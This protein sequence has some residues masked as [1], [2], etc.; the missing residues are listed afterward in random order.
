[1]RKSV[2]KLF[3]VGAA[4][5]LVTLA[6]GGTAQKVITVCPSGCDFTSI[7]AAI[8]AAPDGST[9]QVK[10]GTYQE[11]LT[12]TKPLS[13]LGEGPDKTIIQGG[14]VIQGGQVQLADLGVTCCPPPPPP[15]IIVEPAG[16]MIE[17]EVEERTQATLERVIVSDGFFASLLVA[18]AVEVVLRDSQIEGG[19][20][21]DIQDRAYV[22][23]QSSRFRGTLITASLEASGPAVPQVRVQDSQFSSGWGLKVEGSVQVTVQNSTISGNWGNGLHVWGQAQVTLQNSTISDNG[24]DGLV[25]GG[26]ARA[27]VIGNAFLNNKGYGINAASTDNIVEC[28]GN[29]FEGNGEGPTYPSSLADRCR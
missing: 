2:F 21:M 22:T 12:I 24:R 9:I 27:W 15:P 25:V 6:A 13:V 3:G 26:S 1:M 29:R 8:Q 19:A 10:A 14:I 20:L 5:V 28:R 7:Q 23:V 18:G 17:D 16:I 11:S 4:L